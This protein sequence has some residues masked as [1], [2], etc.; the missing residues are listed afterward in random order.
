MLNNSKKVTYPA[1]VP[2]AK[3]GL[4]NSNWRLLTKK[5]GRLL[6]LAGDQRIEHLNGDFFGAG[7]DQADNDPEHFFQIA[8]K[9]PIGAAAVHYGLASWY[10]QRYNRSAYIIKLNGKTNLLPGDPVSHCLAGVGQAIDLAKQGGFRLA[11]VGYTIYL[12]SQHEGRMLAEAAEIIRQAHSNGLLAVVW[13]YPKGANVKNEDSV[14]TIAGAAGVAVSL[15]ADFVKLKVPK[16]LTT[17]NIQRIVQAAGQTKVVFA[18]GSS[19][20]A[21]QVFKDIQVQL[22]AGAAGVAIG[23][24]I[25]Q[26]SLAE[27]SSWLRGLSAM[28]YENKTAN[29]ALDWLKPNKTGRQKIK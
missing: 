2:K 25:H 7:I 16:P 22:A 9:A 27:A 15:G 18:G 1:D 24:N 26:R 8:D 11:G 12:G 4:Y 3:R 10:G 23:R 13:I 5:T 29:Q 21:N 6:L 19:R 14:E 28:I 17:K 20:T